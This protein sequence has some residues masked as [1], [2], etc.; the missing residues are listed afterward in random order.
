MYGGPRDLRERLSGRVVPDEAVCLARLNGVGEALERCGGSLVEA[1]VRDAFGA[2]LPEHQAV[3][4]RVRGGEAHVSDAH[5]TKA[6]QRLLRP[7]RPLGGVEALGEGAEA[8]LG[9]RRKKSGLA[10][11]V[12]ICRAARDAD[13]L[14]ERAHRDA[15]HAVRSH[16]LG[17]RV[18]ERGAQVTVVIR[19]L[20]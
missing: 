5:L 4:R 17:R 15:V 10:V 12:A 19:V 8:V 20:H 11:E 3:A 14:G 7:R 1:G 9:H 13:A 18:D 16:D 2:A 6:H